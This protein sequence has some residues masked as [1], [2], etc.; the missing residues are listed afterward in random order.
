MP[1]RAVFSAEPYDEVVSMLLHA[2]QIEGERVTAAEDSQRFD[3]Q[4]RNYFPH[5]I[6]LRRE[7]LQVH[8][9]GKLRLEETLDCAKHLVHFL[10]LCGLVQ[11]QRPAP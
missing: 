2:Q 3:Y 5:P 10:A 11:L 8:E 1:D 4:V 9:H 6:A 7:Q